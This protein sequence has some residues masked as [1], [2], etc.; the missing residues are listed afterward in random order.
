[1]TLGVRYMDV[2]QQL[3]AAYNTAD[4]DLWHQAEQ[5]VRSLKQGIVNDYQAEKAARRAE[6]EAQK[7]AKAQPQAAPAAPAMSSEE[8]AAFELFKRFM[9]GDKEAV[10]QVNT[11]LKAA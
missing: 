2:A 3:V 4:R 7:A 1:M 5:A 10:A 9:A 8:Q 11:L 6:R